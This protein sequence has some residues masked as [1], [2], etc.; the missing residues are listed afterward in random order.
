M[1]IVKSV[2][3]VIAAAAMLGG[4]AVADTDLSNYSY[5]SEASTLAPAGGGDVE[6]LTSLRK[7]GA[8]KIG[9]DINLDVAAIRRDERNNDSDQF[10]RTEF[11]TQDAD[12]N[13]KVDATADAS[14]FIKLDLDD[15]SD[16]AIDERE[17][18]EEVYFTWKNV[19]GSNFT[20][21][22]GKKEAPFGLDTTYTITNPYTNNN[23]NGTYLGKSYP[24]GGGSNND[25]KDVSQ[26]GFTHPGEV[27][28]VFSGQVNYAYKDLA[29][30]ELAVFQNNEKDLQG[31]RYGQHEDNSEDTLLLNSYAAR[32]TLK[33]VEGLSLS[34]SFINQHL[35]EYE[36]ETQ[37]IADGEEDNYAISTGFDYKLPNAPLRFYGEYLHGWNQQHKDD[38]DTDTLQLGVVWGV[39]EKIDL[40]L[41]GEW[42]NIDNDYLANEIDEDFYRLA[43]AAWYKTDYGVKF[44]VEYLHEWYDSDN[45]WD[46]ADAD[47]FSFRTSYLF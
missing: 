18:L 29:L 28:N 16:A 38:V 4:I 10:D 12:L 21:I 42:L 46:D 40:V 23:G 13:I 32:T 17:F 27:D 24:N 44:G 14:L 2:A 3:T 43:V 39:T 5:A 34:L 35:D 33:P 6:S 1:R 36:D 41:D 30:F 47:V 45:N 15:F 20:T 37:S 9:G 26:T 19:R 7:K 8:V 11:Y 25:H 31:N 22:L